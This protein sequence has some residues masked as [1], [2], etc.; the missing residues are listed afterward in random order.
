MFGKLARVAM[1]VGGVVIVCLI[2]WGMFPVI[3]DLIG[4]AAADPSAGNYIGYE[5]ALGA[6]PLWLY[7]LPVVIG[8]IW[9][10]IVLRAPEPR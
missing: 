6:A 4:V 5:E 10:V 2:I 8:I 9:I 1:I 7:G 3:Q